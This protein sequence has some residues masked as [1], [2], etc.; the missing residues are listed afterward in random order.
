M[1]RPIRDK[2]GASAD[3]RELYDR[4]VRSSRDALVTSAAH[5]PLEPEVYPQEVLQRP[6]RERIAAAEAGQPIT[7][8]W[9]QLPRDRRYQDD[10]YTYQLHPDGRLTVNRPLPIPNN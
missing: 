3:L 5:K 4:L 1:P 2:P 10:Q 7:V 9:F 6:D 8:F